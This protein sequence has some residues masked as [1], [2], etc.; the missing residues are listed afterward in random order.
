MEW[1]Y[2]DFSSAWSGL[3]QAY[4]FADGYLTNSSQ[5]RSNATASALGEG[6]Q[7]T[8]LHLN[9]AISWISS[10]IKTL[11]DMYDPT[12][13]SYMMACIYY[14][15]VSVPEPE[16]VTWQQIVEAWIAN[17]FEGRV[18]TVATI[19]RMRQIL[20]DEP[21]SVQW[22]ARPEDQDI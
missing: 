12:N 20:W 22:A 6:W 8:T 14:S 9:S 10:A 1:G 13:E 15:A 3:E 16:P 11:F 2:D 18:A 7:T 19:D 5:S 21:F 4:D 17:D